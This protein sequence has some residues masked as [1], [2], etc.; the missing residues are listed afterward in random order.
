MNTKVFH[1][2]TELLRFLDL[3]ARQLESVAQVGH[4]HASVSDRKIPSVK[5]SYGISTDDA[6]LACKKRG[7]QI[8]TCSVLKEGYGRIGSASLKI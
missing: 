2:C 8:L 7:H 1:H 3:Q 4:K 6:C 5:T